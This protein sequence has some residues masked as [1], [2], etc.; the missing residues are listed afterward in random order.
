MPPNTE[1]L[2]AAREA[3]GLTQAELARRVGVSVDTIGRAERGDR[4]TPATTIGRIAR[5]LGVSLESLLVIEET[6]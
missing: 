2:R 1:A 6:K 4:D 3:A 5:V